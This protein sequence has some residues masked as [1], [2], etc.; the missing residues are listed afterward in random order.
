MSYNSSLNEGEQ[1][2]PPI[3]KAVEC[4]CSLNN[5][6]NPKSES[7]KDPFNDARLEALMASSPYGPSP[8]EQGKTFFNYPLVNPAI[9]CIYVEYR[10][11]SGESEYIPLTK[12][13]EGFV[14]VLDIPNGSLYKL[15]ITYNT[16]NV[17]KVVDPAAPY[18]PNGVLNHDD[19]HA[20]G[21][22]WDQRSYSFIHPRPKQAL[23][24][25]PLFSVFHVGVATKEGTFQAAKRLLPA[26]K[27]QG[28]DVIQL[29][30]VCAVVGEAN[31]GYD[32]VTNHFSVNKNYGTPDDMKSFIDEAH[33]LGL[34]VIL[35]VVYNHLSMDIT[36]Q[37]Y[38][39]GNE[40]V[41]VEVKDG[42]WGK[43]P[44]FQNKIVHDYIVRNIDF[45]SEQFNVD[46]FR[47]DAA[48]RIDPNMVND[49]WLHARSNNPD[50]II[51]YEGNTRFDPKMDLVR[52][53]GFTNHK[54][55]ITYDTGLLWVALIGAVLPADKRHAFYKDIARDLVHGDTRINSWRT[56][57]DLSKISGDSI[58]G[59]CH[60]FYGNE[61]PHQRLLPRLC[62]IFG[63][64]DGFVATLGVFSIILTTPGAKMIFLGDESGALDSNFSYF[65][66]F[67]TEEI[68][69][70]VS[71]GRVKEWSDCFIDDEAD[72]QAVLRKWDGS[73][74]GLNQL[75]KS[76]KGDISFKTYKFLRYH[77]PHR[78]E[79]FISAKLSS[80]NLDEPLSR[81]WKEAFTDMV[82]FIR[83]LNTTG[84]N[85]HVSHIGNVHHGC[86]LLFTGMK[87]SDKD[88][89]MVAN[90]TDEYESIQ[91]NNN[92][93]SCSKDE[94][95][96]S[97]FEIIKTTVDGQ[98]EF[99]APEE[100]DTKPY[101]IVRDEVRNVVRTN[102][103][104]ERPKIRKIIN[105]NGEERLAV[106]LP[107]HGLLYIKREQVQ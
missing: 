85:L 89:Y 5:S 60:D 2:M 45:W 59:L 88:V 35:D 41:D 81:A 86:V 91:I 99:L 56:A 32:G 37:E 12:K 58:I 64:N 70:F 93:L 74:E 98:N 95:I 78:P 107:P 10:N 1:S 75:Y 39:F 51:V 34:R 82:S 57:S 52:A 28:F 71:R 20:W 97:H 15:H 103:P 61:P 72:L 29:M 67:L 3:E 54:Y 6:P 11:Q 65:R 27:E 24:E 48:H 53:K 42:K 14:G 30:P 92:D 77:L 17:E 9:K 38:L 8:L 101:N 66:S 31:W 79:L 76:D 69:N 102:T 21:Q 16:E 7:G 90:I 104:M 94:F 80:S 73:E 44:N 84:D 63:T 18:L 47:L 43:Q 68:Q 19:K 46:G 96:S 26:L 49:I 55:D 106:D 33:R 22:I 105:A 100:K 4:D 40:F 23:P 87:Q 50:A 13:N 62:E 83:T 36:S 25:H